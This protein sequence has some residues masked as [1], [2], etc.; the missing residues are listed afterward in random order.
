MSVDTSAD[1]RLAGQRSLQLLLLFAVILSTVFGGELLVMYLLERLLPAESS[2]WTVAL[3]D[4]G[5]LSLLVTAVVLPFMLHLRRIHLRQ[6]RNT[7]RLQYTLD[8]HAIVS[9]A[10]IKGRI[11]FANDRFCEI[12]GYT[13]QEL[14]GH[15]HR[16]LKSGEHSADYYREMWQTVAQGRIW[17]GDICN[18]AKDGSLYWVRATI[19]P[20]L[21]ENGKPEEY[22]AIRTDISAQKRLEAASQRQEMWLRTILDN[23]GEGVYSLSVDGAVTYLNKEGE[24]LL[25]WSLEDLRGKS[26]HDCIHHHRPDGTPIPADQCLIRQAMHENRLFRSG[27]EYF[28]RKDGSLLPV[29]ITGAP[30]LLDGVRLGSVAVFAD[31]SEQRQ[32]QQHLLDAKDAAEKAARLKSDF[33]STMSHEIRTPLNGV[34]GMTDLLLDTRLDSE[35]TDFARIIKT[36][37]DAL[38]AIVSDILDFSKIEAGRLAIE[39][40]DFSLRQTV[41]STLDVLSG[42]RTNDNLLLSSFIAPDLPD[43][44]IGDPTRVRQ[45]LLNFLSNAIK[46]TERGH[47]TVSAQVAERTAAADG[48]I[49]LRLAVS[50]TGIGISAQDQTSLFLPFSQ[51]DSSTTRKYGGTGLGLSITKRLAEAMGGHVGVVS[52]P[53][54]GSTFWVELSFA[55]GEEKRATRSGAL[56]AGAARDPRRRCRRRSRH[57]AGLS[58]GLGS[59]DGIGPRIGG[60][61]AA[62]RCCHRRTES[63]RSGLGGPAIAG[64]QPVRN[65]GRAAGRR[66]HAADDL[67]P[68]GGAARRATGA[69]LPGSARACRTA[70]SILALSRAGGRTGWR[71]ADAR[72]SRR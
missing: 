35:Q 70:A 63:L 29:K 37:A 33:L 50:D 55:V 30:L 18:R 56:A 17:H 28:I 60:T 40:T 54:K 21:G 45:I 58:S 22:I 25:G 12:S 64:C 3:L 42:K 36:S 8:H 66:L 39:A 1:Q 41:E 67:L 65:D 69:R 43:H 46:F 49:S 4:A 9:I 26:L 15:D 20:F 11:T 44:L 13:R 19:T 61:G 32:L 6:A 23:I 59:G 57:L 2:E 5:L 48:R 34:I 62:F 52:E 72:A 24:R 27:D 68:A 71:F 31:A 10:D 38:M 53:G 47:V 7:L 51:T 14:I 16:I